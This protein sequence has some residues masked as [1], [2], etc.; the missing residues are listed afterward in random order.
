MNLAYFVL[1]VLGF[2]NPSNHFKKLLLPEPMTLQECSS[3]QAELEILHNS[4]VQQLIRN[5]WRTIY[6]DCVKGQGI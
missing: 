6:W 1:L 5:G 4:D 3:I 2:G